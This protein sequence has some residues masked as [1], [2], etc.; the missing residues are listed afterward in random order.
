MGQPELNA[1]LDQ[2][3]LRQLKQRV[4][5][6][7]RLAPLKDEETGR[8]ID[9]RLRAAGYEGKDLF[10]PDAVRQIAF[11]SK[12]IPRLINIIC[13]NALLIAYAGSKKIVSADMI[14]DVGRDLR[15]G[16]EVQVTDAAPI[17]TVLAPK[18]ETPVHEAPNEVPQHKVRRRVEVGVGTLLAILAFVVVASVI[19]P[20][21][22]LSI[23]ANRLEASKHNLKQWVGLVT[24]QQAVTEKI[25]AEVITRQQ[26]V[27]EAVNAETTTRQQAVPEKTNAEA[28]RAVRKHPRVMIQHGSTIHKIASGVYGANTLLGM[29]LIKEFNPQIRNLNWVFPGQDLLLPSLTQETMLRKRPDGSYRLIVASFPSLTEAEKYARL[30][31]NEGYQIM[32]TPKWVADDL[33]LHRVE[34]DGLKNLEEV[35]QI[36]ETGLKNQ[37]FAFVGSPRSGT[38]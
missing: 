26:A 4:A 24:R 17:P 12:G 5:L 6:Q 30:L 14:K 22:F 32:I 31:G 19:D 38:R 11:Y 27:P 1:R 13:D 15:L 18:R 10:Q 36:W 34:I 7:C 29:D 23:A 3:M 35:D 37:W 20:Q 16:P 33:L 28:E 8:Y 21:N 9:F 2:P 25:T